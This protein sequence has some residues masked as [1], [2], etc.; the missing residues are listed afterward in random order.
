LRISVG[1]LFRLCERPTT[2]R[3]LPVGTFWHSGY[4]C[5]P[6]SSPSRMILREAKVEPAIMLTIVRY[7]D[8]TIGIERDYRPLAGCRWSGQDV[9]TALRVFKIVKAGLEGRSILRL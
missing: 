9:G 1:E 4:K 2:Q 3:I 5:L 6:M 8:G 7:A